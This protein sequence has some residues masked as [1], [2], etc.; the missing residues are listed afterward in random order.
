MRITSLMTSRSC[1]LSFVKRSPDEE[2]KQAESGNQ[3]TRCWNSTARV[4]KRLSHQPATCLRARYCSSVPNSGRRI[5]RLISVVEIDHLEDVVF[6]FALGYLDHQP[7]DVGAP[8][9]RRPA[10]HGIFAAVVSCG[11]RLRRA[12]FREQV[13][14]VLR[15]EKDRRVGAVKIVLFEVAEPQLGGNLIGGRGDELHQPARRR[16]AFFTRVVARLLPCDRERESR[17]DATR[18]RVAGE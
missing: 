4:S 17:I 12:E 10:P 13:F 15:A 18:S 2:F 7:V 16:R 9:P 1:S 5:D 6:G 3:N 8:G 11:Y 14:H